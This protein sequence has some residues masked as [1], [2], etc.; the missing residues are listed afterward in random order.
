[1]SARP[2]PADS[3]RTESSSVRVRRLGPAA[4]GGQRGYSTG[5]RI[6]R[7]PRADTAT[8][9]GLRVSWR[10]GA[11]RA[12]P[13]SPRGVSESG[14]IVMTPLGFRVVCTAEDWERI[15]LIKHPPMRGR[16]LEVARTLSAPDEIRRSQSDS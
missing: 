15:S 11:T 12:V 7:S 13:L 14:F 3:L 4:A 10:F 5:C 16:F 2:G 8:A 6:A 1:S 9:L